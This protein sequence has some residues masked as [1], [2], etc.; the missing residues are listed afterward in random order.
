MIDRRQLLADLKP[1]VRMIEDD[2]RGRLDILSTYKARLES[3]WAAARA[4]ERTAE[5]FAAWADAQFTQ[6]AVAW[7]LACVFVRFCEDNGL[8]DDAFVAGNGE[9]GRRAAARQEAFYAQ[10]PIAADNDYLRDVFAV[11]G[12]LPGLADVFRVQASP[13]S[14]PVSADAAKRLVGFFRAID[15]DSGA[16]KHDFADPAWN[17]RFLGDLYQ[18]LS[19]AARDRYALLQTPEFVE[20]FILDRTLKP[21]LDTYTLEEAD[22]I[23]PTCGSG[24]FVLGAF[25]RLAPKWLNKEPGNANVAIQHALDHIAGIDLNPFAVAIARFRLLVAALKAAGVT[26]LKVA[27]DFHLRIAVGDSLLHGFDQRDHARAQIALGLDVPVQ[28]PTAKSNTANAE[29]AHLYTHAFASEDL[30]A[31]N[32]IL[33]HHY[34]VV[35]GNPPYITV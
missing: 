15:A 34:T 8:I 13:L 3:D 32:D 5:S 21:A 30:K 22:L 4:A 25:A 28:T 16:L 27:P 17:T 20:E 18:D 14:A 6:S 2:L 35:V 7:L 24:H 12:K 26:R 19:E 11:A 31:A 29:L 9:H 33:S 1:F 10:N 23:D